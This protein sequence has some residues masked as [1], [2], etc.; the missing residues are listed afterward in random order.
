MKVEAVDLALESY[1]HKEKY[2]KNWRSISRKIKKVLVKFLED[3]KLRVIVFGSVVRGNFTPLSD[4][5]LLIVSE[6]VKP[7]LEE[8]VMIRRKIKECLNDPYPP[9]E[10]HVAS[11]KLFRNWY[12]KFIDVYVEA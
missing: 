2:F 8:I 6:K 11:P 7:T 12:K 4:I 5:D 3:K 1:K 9:L 10:I